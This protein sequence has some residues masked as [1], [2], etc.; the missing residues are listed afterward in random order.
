MGLPLPCPPPGLYAAPAPLPG[1]T[2]PPALHAHCRAWV[3]YLYSCRFIP[4]RAGALRLDYRW[5]RDT[6][7][8]AADVPS[9]PVSH[10]SLSPGGREG[11][12]SSHGRRP[13]RLAVSR[14][15]QWEEVHHS[16]ESKDHTE[17]LPAEVG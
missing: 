9:P 7:T 6:D 11:K 15:G 12:G 16:W 17:V 5:L 2:G 14:G 10:Y 13:V 3:G 1:H 8:A 4:R